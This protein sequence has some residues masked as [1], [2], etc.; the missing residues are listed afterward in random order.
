MSY[1]LKLSGRG[2]GGA[3]LHRGH[4]MHVPPSADHHESQSSY[5]YRRKTAS[6]TSLP[7]TPPRHQVVETN[8]ITKTYDTITGNKVI[9]NYMIVREIGR[10]VHGKVKLGRHVETGELC[11][12]KIVDRT[13]RRRLGKGIS[14]MTN[15]Q[16]V[17][18]EIAIMK[19]CVHPNVV[20]LKEVIDDPSTRKIYMVLEYVEGGEIRWKDS[21][22]QPILRL[23]QS[24]RALR[25]VV[26]GL[27]YLHFQG[28]I[29]RDIKPA[30]LLMTKEGIVK[31]SDFGVSYFN[32][33]MSGVLSDH[34]KSSWQDDL[35]LAKTVG[36]PAFF[37]PELCFMG[38]ISV[39]NSSAS[40]RSSASAASATGLPPTASQPASHYSHRK[41]PST[42]ISRPRITKAIDIWALGV[43]L[44]CFVFGR[45][46]FIAETEYELFNIIPNQPLQF[47]SDIPIPEELEDL[48][49]RLLEK[50]P[51][52]RITLDE[53]K[54][55][56]WTTQD[57]EDPQKWIE[58]TDPRRYQ[59]AEVTE[60]EVK[61]AVTI[62]GRLKQQ[63]RKL[64]TSL[65]NMS[66]GSLRRRSKSTSIGS[67]SHSSSAQLPAPLGS[68][69]FWVAQDASPRQPNQLL[70][71][72]SPSSPATPSIPTSPTYSY[73]SL[74][75]HPPLMAPT[76]SDGR[77]SHSS[78]AFGPFGASVPTGLGVVY[79]ANEHDQELSGRT[80]YRSGYP[81]RRSEFGL[82]AWDRD[83][84][85]EGDIRYAYPSESGFDAALVREEVLIGPPSRGS[86][87]YSES[88][89]S[90]FISASAS[91]GR[92]ERGSGE[93]N[94]TTRSSG[95]YEGPIPQV[96]SAFSTVSSGPV[97]FVAGPQRGNSGGNGGG[98]STGGLVGGGSEGGGVV[99]RVPAG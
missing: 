13:T 55:H 40:L 72:L 54:R 88:D 11:A 37:A 25:D 14:Q 61:S 12:I 82:S 84:V 31:I 78:P 19:K 80:R 77:S 47:P 87:A 71:S 95:F 32:E 4:T 7:G 29:H 58:E 91:T 69:M 70:N 57:L 5:R 64:S 20:R 94:S 24:R 66:F 51:E 97:E 85:H 76:V 92:V 60:E 38:D 73:R 35:E 46:P 6:H 36:S 10:G 22:D 65:S 59:L 15:E 3:A 17:R 83:A 23:D 62:I 18:R 53:I 96:Y 9:N 44:F 16:K 52:K 26:A 39:D 42:S 43:T 48:F 86:F 8:T 45:C 90:D 79:D 21:N 1:S 93:G 2:D 81:R 99:K 98:V 56:P 74:Q 49:L 41:Q 68:P 27:Q 89:E 30:N 75:P 28:I 63:F 50:N 34:Q 33:H 67:G